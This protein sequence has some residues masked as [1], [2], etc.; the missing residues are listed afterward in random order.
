MQLIRDRLRSWLKIRVPRR[1]PPLGPKPR[2]GARIVQGRYRMTVTC[3]PTDELWYFVS[4]L[5]WRE[6]SMPR[7]RRRY[8][9]LPRA[10]FDLLARS[11]PSQRE[12]RYRQLILASTRAKAPLA[13]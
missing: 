10:S 1:N 2:I 12:T 9:D 4:L 3:Q 6:V 11:A 7:D 13:Y 8:V 5:G